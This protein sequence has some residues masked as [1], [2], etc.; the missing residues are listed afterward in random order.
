MD[1]AEARGH[2]SRERA[3]YCIEEVSDHA[4]CAMI[5]ALRR[6]LIAGDRSVQAGAWDWTAAGGLGLLAGTRVGVVGF[7][8]IGRRLAASAQALGMEVRHHDPFVPGGAEFDDLLAWATT[9]SLHT[10][11]TDDTRG[12]IDARRLGLMRP[13]AILVNTARR[14][15]RPGGSEGGDARPGPRSTTCGSGR[16]AATCSAFPT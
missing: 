7:G 14:R 11:L 1:A 15:G 2:R 4:L 12:L 13:G 8:R 16:R 3:D 9:R 10:P 6:G 5:V